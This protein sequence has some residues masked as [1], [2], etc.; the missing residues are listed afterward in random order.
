MRPTITDIISKLEENKTRLGITLYK[1]ASESEI[2]AF[3]KSKCV[4]LPDDLVTFYSYC[5]GFES[6]ADIFRIIPLNEIIENKQDGYTA[7]SKDFHFAE[8]MAYCD[9]WT[10]SINQH[11]NN[12]YSIYNNAKNMITLTNSI[13][14]FLNT[15]LSAGIIDGLYQWRQEI[16]MGEK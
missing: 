9:M 13:A 4:K 11:D 6:V 12:V 1:K 8:Y 16:E 3:E 14:E 15:F 2:S 10:I 7:E 5:N